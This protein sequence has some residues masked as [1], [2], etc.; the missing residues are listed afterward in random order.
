MRRRRKPS[1]REAKASFSASMGEVHPLKSA[2][3][4]H[5]LLTL[6]AIAATGVM[7]GLAGTKTL[8]KTGSLAVKTLSASALPL[9]IIKK[10]FL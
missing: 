6:G 5:P 8:K 7:V 2:M 4:I 10:F 9:A 1:L 3:Q